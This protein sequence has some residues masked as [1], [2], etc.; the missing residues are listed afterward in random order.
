MNSND[1]RAGLKLGFTAAGTLIGGPIGGTIGSAIGTLAGTLIPTKT[2]IKQKTSFNENVDQNMAYSRADYGKGFLNYTSEEREKATT[3][4]K[5]ADIAADAIPMVANA[6]GFK[7]LSDIKLP[8]IGNK[9][10]AIS[11]ADE[12]ISTGNNITSEI[13]SAIKSDTM[14]KVFNYGTK[15]IGTI[16]DMI[17]IFGTKETNKENQNKQ[18]PI[19]TNFDAIDFDSTVNNIMKSIDSSVFKPIESYKETLYKPKDTPFNYVSD[20]PIQRMKSLDYVNNPVINTQKPIYNIPTDL[21]N[22]DFEKEIEQY[23]KRNKNAKYY[24]SY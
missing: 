17:D 18:I 22:V 23:K 21:K 9:T 3:F 10:D 24:M 5:V 13:G 4:S 2:F 14:K 16:N 20:K 1:A 19:E 15:S 12:V 6:G 7:G 8:S 11:K